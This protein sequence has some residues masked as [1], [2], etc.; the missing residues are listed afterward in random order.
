MSAKRSVNEV[1]MKRLPE[2]GNRRN[3]SIDHTGLHRRPQIE[4][5]VNYL[6]NSQEH[7]KFPDG[8]AKF[9]AN[10]PFMTQLIFSICKK[11]K[12]ERG[13]IKSVMK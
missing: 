3:K 7:A 8:E 9:I 6:A 11:S 2:K 1:V 5:I 4:Q 10:R 13:K 12:K